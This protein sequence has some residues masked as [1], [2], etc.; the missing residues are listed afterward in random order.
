MG[1]LFSSIECGCGCGNLLLRTIADRGWRYIRGHKPRQAET[2]G[3]QITRRAKV[4][5][6]A[7]AELGEG[8]LRAA[9]KFLIAQDNDL[10]RQEDDAMREWNAAR[11]R[12]DAVHAQRIKIDPSLRELKALLGNVDA[13][14]EV[15]REGAA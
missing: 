11:T 7:V 3:Q 9:L 14:A 13:G 10:S 6:G 1:D 4:K 12:F 15:A 5:P 8:A 2:A